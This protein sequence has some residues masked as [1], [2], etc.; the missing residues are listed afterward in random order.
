MQFR[1]DRLTSRERIDALFAR[2]RPDR[3]P[4][5]AMSTG[6]GTRNAGYSVSDA[7][8][9]PEKAFQGT[10]WTTEQYGWDPVP[11]YSGHTVLGIMDFGGEVRMPQGEYEGALVFKSHPVNSEKDVEKLKLPD[12]KTAGRIPQ[13]MAFARLQAE[14]RLPVYF[15]SRSP[16]T[17]AGTI[18]RLEQFCKWLIKKPELCTMLM[19]L[20]L[21]HICNVLQYWVDTFGTDRLIAWMSSPSESNQVISPRVMEKFALPYHIEYHRRLRALGIKRFG[22]HVCGDQNLN[23]PRL[24]EASPWPH[25]SVLSF[26]H[27]VDIETAARYFPQ[28]IIFGNIEPAVFQIGPPQKV[29]E[30]CKAAIEKG[31]KAEGGYILGPGCGLPPTAPAVNVYAMTKAAHDFGW[32]E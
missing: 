16:F 6:F 25:P 17:M 5:G 2:K 32:Y 15:F 14:H 27:E 22:L 8:L 11:Q 23:L 28:D 7:Y 19:D 20:A 29:Y 12:P 13:A 9:N 10:L 3:V 1:Q 26:G 18:T 21:E 30:L 24:S 31:K 4:V